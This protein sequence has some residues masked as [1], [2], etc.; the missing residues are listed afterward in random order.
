M[1]VQDRE[2]GYECPRG[3]A[4]VKVR[5]LLDATGVIREGAA[6]RGA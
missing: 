6:F 4:A 2:V 1:Y 5:N 3:P